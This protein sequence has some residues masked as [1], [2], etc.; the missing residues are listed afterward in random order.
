MKAYKKKGFVYLRAQDND[1]CGTYIP[2]KLS[3]SAT[4]H[5]Y[6]PLKEQDQEA[7]GQP[8]DSYLILDESA[9]SSFN[10]HLSDSLHKF[11]FQSL[12]DSETAEQKLTFG[13]I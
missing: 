5:P 8:G 6:L 9:G 11:R 1:V 2:E 10:Q 4:T 13:G 3:I 12:R 7:L